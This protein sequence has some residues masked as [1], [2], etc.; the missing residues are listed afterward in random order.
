MKS[1]TRS[2]ACKPTYEIA[3]LRPKWSDL[4]G[5]YEIN[6]G[7]LPGNLV[8]LITWP[9]RNTHGIRAAFNHIKGGGLASILHCFLDNQPIKAACSGFT[10]GCL[11]CSEIS[12]KMGAERDCFTNRSTRRNRSTFARGLKHP[13]LEFSLRDCLSSFSLYSL[14]FQFRYDLLHEMPRTAMENYLSS[15][16]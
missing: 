14:S 15:E 3:Y 7:L 16:Q 9:G 6:C 11:C 10:Y 5:G 13:T 12:S 8:L 4:L 1:T 2:T